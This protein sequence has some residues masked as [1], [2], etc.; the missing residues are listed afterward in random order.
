MDYARHYELSNIAALVLVGSNAGLP[1]APTDPV[2]TAR[3]AAQ[4]DANRQ[5]PPDI[6]AQITNGKEFVKLMTAHPASLTMQ[7][8]MFATN[9][10]LPTY[11]RRAMHSLAPD[12]QDLSPRSINPCSSSS[13]I[14]I[15]PSPSRRSPAW[16]RRSRWQ[17]CRSWLDPGTRPLSMHPR[18]SIGGYANSSRRIRDD[19]TT[20]ALKRSGTLKRVG[21]DVLVE[22]IELVKV[23]QAVRQR[24]DGVPFLRRRIDAQ[25]APLAG[26]AKPPSLRRRQRHARREGLR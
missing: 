8:V 16:P 22:K 25:D 13:A 20:S 14:R 17:R 4:R 26:G 2:V 6:P 19:L 12:N 5:A 1:P 11:A 3:L 23:Q 10:M 21:A 9:Q 15:R 7:Q 24:Y 18:T